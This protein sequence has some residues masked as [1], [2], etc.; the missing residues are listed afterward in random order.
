MPTLAGSKHFSIHCFPHWLRLFHVLRVKNTSLIRQ[1]WISNCFFARRHNENKLNKRSIV[2]H[3]EERIPIKFIR[4]NELT[5]GIDDFM[6]ECTSSITANRLETF[7]LYCSSF[8]PSHSR[9]VP[10]FF[11]ALLTATLLSE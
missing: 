5:Q 7:I 8:L 11:V 2:F 1:K 10:Y 6:L 3:N 4:L 9:T